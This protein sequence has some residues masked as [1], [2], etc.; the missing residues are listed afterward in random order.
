[1]HYLKASKEYYQKQWP[2]EETVPIGASEEDVRVL[3]RRLGFRLPEA[4]RELLLWMGKDYAGILSDEFWYVDQIEDMT[5]HLPR[6]LKENGLP[7]PE[8]KY[9]CLYTHQGYVKA[10]YPMPQASEDPEIFLYAEGD[11]EHPK[12]YIWGYFSEWVLTSLKTSHFD[13][14]A[15]QEAREKYDAE[16][17]VKEAAVEADSTASSE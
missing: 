16:Q 5:K 11:K 6:L 8:G 1:M 15:Q 13:I 2:R 7:P 12:P 14:W 10:W 9:V 17:Q 4:H 3:E